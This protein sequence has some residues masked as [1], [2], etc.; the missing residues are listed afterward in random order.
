[1]FQPNQKARGV[2][3]HHQ[4]PSDLYPEESSR[5]WR[6]R[7]VLWLA[8]SCFFWTNPHLASLLWWSGLS[9]NLS[10]SFEMRGKLSCWSSRTP[11]RRSRFLLTLTSS[12]AAASSCRGNPSSSSPIPQL[13]G[14]TWGRWRDVDF[15]QAFT[16]ALHVPTGHPALLM[17]SF[18]KFC[19]FI[20]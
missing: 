10:A 12:N 14:R 16:A 5:C 4:V 7:G 19:R 6:L 2:P 9:L 3:V 13:P 20:V 17:C 8:P 18:L 1:M 15:R 11:G